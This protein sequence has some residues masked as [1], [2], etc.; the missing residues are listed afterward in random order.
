[1]AR[2]SY[3]EETVV[4][5]AARTASGNSG[6]LTGYGDASTLRALLAVTAV[7]GTTPSMTV[8]IED[9]LDGTNWFT[10]GT[11]AAKTATGVEVIN[12]TA[13][14]AERLRVSWAITGTTPSFTFALTVASQ[15]P[16]SS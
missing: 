4:S 1:M 16:S 12:V 8:L 15:T 2:L 10:I 11:F 6:V 7:S 9:T 14:F 13:P 5:S 3:L